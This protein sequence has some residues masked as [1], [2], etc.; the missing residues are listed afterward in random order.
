MKQNKC[1]RFNGQSFQNESWQ[2]KKDEKDKTRKVNNARN[3][4]ILC[5]KC[6]STELSY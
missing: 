3:V 5:C 6:L 1:R 2:H 4:G